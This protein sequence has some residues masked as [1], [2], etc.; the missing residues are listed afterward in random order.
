[1]DFRFSEDQ[2]SIQELSRKIFES[3]VSEESL[4][5]LSKSK[6]SV[7]RKVWEALGEAEL[8]GIALPVEY[9]GGGMGLVELGILLR[10]Q[11]RVAAPIPLMNSSGVAAMTLAKFG[12][13]ALKGR[14]LRP[15]ASGESVI[16]SALAQ[17]SNLNFL[18]PEVQATT[19][20]DGYLLS[21]SNTCVPSLLSADWVLV[22]ASTADGHVGL[23]LVNPKDA[24]VC[25]ESQITTSFEE[26]GEL[27]L[28]GVK[29]SSENLVGDLTQD[30]SQIQW[31]VERMWA[32]ICALQWGIAERQLEMLAEFAKTRKQFGQPIGAF[33]AVSQRAGDAYIDLQSMAVTAQQALWRLAE[34][35]DATAEVM[36][37]KYWAS[38]GGHRIA[39]S[40]QHI[41]GGMGV[42][43]DYPL[44]RYSL[45]ARQLELTLGGANQ[46]LARLGSY[47]AI[48]NEAL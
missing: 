11:G 30:G 34:D 22:P 5:A 13:E 27:T 46:M 2:S 41:H 33:Q 45:L 32:C 38:Q 29:V 17:S 7:H 24:G 3:E 47:L 35:K 21:G 28:D 15:V 40:A 25:I 31:M 9:G 26:Q 36:I 6:E 37:A 48:R 42:D 44:F 10:E 43:C 8:L 1:M 16:T 14:L 23:F 20:G 18:K 4:K 39:A 19:G 12:D